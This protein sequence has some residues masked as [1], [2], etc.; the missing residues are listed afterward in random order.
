MSKI[1]LHDL[2]FTPFISEEE[3]SAIVSSLVQKVSLDV[4]EN[5]IPLFIGILNGSFLFA[6][7]FLR[8]YKQN[9]EI[10]FVL[11]YESLLP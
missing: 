4:D 7:D 11:S 10:S 1:K 9:C 6:A 2:Y 5:E 3:I 8:K